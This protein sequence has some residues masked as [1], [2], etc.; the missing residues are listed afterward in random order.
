LLA[1]RFNSAGGGD[2]GWSRAWA[3]SLAARSFLNYEVHDSLVHLLTHLTYGTSL[4]DTGPPAPFQIDGN[5]G[6][7]AG[8]AEALVQS[9]ELVKETRKTTASRGSQLQPTF[10][11]YGSS[12]KTTLL[13]LLPALPT[14]W[15]ENGGGSVQGLRA[16]GGFEVDISWNSD[17]DLI[18]ANITSLLGQDVWLTV[19][20][21]PIG[22]DGAKTNLTGSAISVGGETGRFVLLSSEKGKSYSVSSS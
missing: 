22:D 7:T 8:I 10:W 4:L 14:Q 1:D 16:R 13:R 3:I 17:G 15:A 11:G 18:G 21:E 20:S 12:S 19:G 5:F 9:H 6:G 2:T